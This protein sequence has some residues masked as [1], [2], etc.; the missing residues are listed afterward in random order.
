MHFCNRGEEL[1]ALFGRQLIISELVKM[2]RYYMLSTK[3]VRGH[4]PITPK[5]SN[6]RSEFGL[7]GSI[8]HH[9]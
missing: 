7:S 5:L 1:N 6:E 3:E 2:P 4:S 9:Q 8:S